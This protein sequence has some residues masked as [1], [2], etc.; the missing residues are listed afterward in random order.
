MISLAKFSSV[1]AD[2]SRAAYELNPLVLSFF[3]LFLA[4]KALVTGLIIFKILT[5]Y[6]EIRGL[7]SHVS[8]ANG[9]GRDIVPITSILIESGVITAMAQLLQTLMYKFEV[10][11][12]PIIGS[13]VVQ[14]YVRNYTGF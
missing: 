8:Y 3:S 12:Y 2:P 11:A 1:Y 5:V 7:E 9:L 13:L 10:T 14:L 4:E 6:C